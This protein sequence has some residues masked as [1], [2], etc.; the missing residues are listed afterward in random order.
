LLVKDTFFIDTASL[1]SR[2]Q[3]RYT[4]RAVNYNMEQTEHSVVVYASPKRNVI[5]PSPAGTRA[6]AEGGRILLGW[7]DV[8][9]S[10]DQV[11]SYTVYR[12]PMRTNERTIEKE[13]HSR[14]LLSD[15]FVI[16]NKEPVS[17]A[18]F[19]DNSVKPGVKYL[20]AITATDIYGV[21]SNAGE[22]ITV[23]AQPVVLMPPAQASARKTSKGIEISWDASRQE[24]VEGYIVF[25]REPN[26]REGVQVAS[27]SKDQTTYTDTRVNKNILYFY[28]VQAKGSGTVSVGSVE[29]GV[30]L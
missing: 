30:R 25:R 2:L 21:E 16:I 12:K 19:E 10:D 7:N 11:V 15:N 26:Q 8:K 5:P 29:K 3:Y 27:V 1:S 24:G 6:I 22:Y 4:V 23:D 17:A 9:S 20:Y 13:M 18:G 28:S 14:E